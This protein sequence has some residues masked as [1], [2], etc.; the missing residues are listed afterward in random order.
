MKINFSNSSIKKK[1]VKIGAKEL[2]W[3]DSQSNIDE[4][5]TIKWKHVLG[6]VYGKVS[7][8]LTKKKF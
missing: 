2:V 7:P 6:V 3:S 4:G 1:F 8:N 5:S